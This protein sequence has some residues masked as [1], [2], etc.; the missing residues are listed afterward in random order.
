VV[1]EWSHGRTRDGAVAQINPLPEQSSE[2][3]VA[4]PSNHR[5]LWDHLRMDPNDPEARIRDLERSLNDQASASELGTSSDE[6]G[7]SSVEAG[8]GQ[9]GYVPPPGGASYPPPP[10]PGSYGQGYPAPPPPPGSYDS[11]FTPPPPPP[12]SYGSYG[13]T[14]PPPGYGSYPPASLSGP[15]NP[16]VKKSGFPTGW[17]LAIIALVFLIPL[18]GGIYAVFSVT[19]AVKDI[20]SFTPPSIPSF[21]AP[22]IPSF[23]PPSIPGHPGSTTDA[24]P[25]AAAGDNLS[26]SGVGVNDKVVCD[27]G[28]VSISGFSNTYEV[29]GNCAQLTVSGS[30]KKVVVDSAD[31]IAISG[32]NNTVTYHSGAP[33]VNN[34]GLDN[35]VGQG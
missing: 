6:L 29:S 33:Q 27:G 7:T 21:S 15:F 35:N 30:Q 19:N 16:T 3:C 28:A 12:G 18:A 1:H 26:L 5:Q 10:P 31:A 13:S 8:S 20:P 14:P 24:V 34:S 22:S 17:L 4:A 11:S 25:T 32:L 23:S 9:Y 2:N